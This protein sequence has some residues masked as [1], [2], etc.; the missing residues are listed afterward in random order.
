LPAAPLPGQMSLETF[1]KTVLDAR[2]QAGK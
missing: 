2:A 1:R